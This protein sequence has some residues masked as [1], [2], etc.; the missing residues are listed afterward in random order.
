MKRYAADALTGRSQSHSRSGFSTRDSLKRA[1]RLLE[2]VNSRLLGVVLNDLNLAVD[3]YYYY[4]YY[5]YY[6]YGRPDRE[7]SNAVGR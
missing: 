3:G 1:K 7:V 6:G 4:Y 5:G 2:H